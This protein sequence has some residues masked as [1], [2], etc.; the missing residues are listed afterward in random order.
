MDPYRNPFSPGAGTPPPEL[1][2]RSEILRDIKIALVRVKAGRP[3]R[4]QLLVGLRGVG[5]TVLLTEVEKIAES[6]GYQTVLIEA[7][8][9]T[10]FMKQLVPHLRK[11]LMRL[12]AGEMVSAEVKRGWRVLRSFVAS[13]KLK[14]GDDI[15][16]GFDG[17]SER[18]AAD[19]GALDLD[20]QE[21]FTAIGTAAA[22]RS[23]GVAIIID[24]LQYLTENEL[25]AVIMAVHKISQRQLPLIVVGAG[26]PQLVGNAGR[27]KSYAE[28]L[29]V[30]PKI[31]PLSDSDAYEALQGPALTQGV[32]FTREALAEIIKITGGYPYFLQEWGFQT[33]NEAKSSP[34]GAEVVS[35]ANKR[36]IERLDSSFFRVRF[37]RL[38]PREKD[39]LRA[40]AELGGSV[41]R[42]GEIASLL[43]MQSAS[44]A[45]LRN[46]LIHK[47]MIYSPQHG[48]TAFTVPLFDQFMKRT[49]PDMPGKKPTKT[50]DG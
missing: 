25:S 29:F 15:E 37:D 32:E 27:A 19:S 42:S 43:G 12:D 8:E 31:G 40:M 1:A 5:K 22:A 33:W 14:L 50:A 18:G 46:T 48:D 30:F 21:V 24:E 23:S 34:I 20:L 6:V 11:L 3:D 17:E 44:A 13:L 38:T 41:S 4:S 9:D 36:A 45:P 7:R 16:I 26:L 47:G 28:R 35:F 39:Y 49:M 2:G 10:P